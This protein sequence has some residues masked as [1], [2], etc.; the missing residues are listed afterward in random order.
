MVFPVQENAPKNKRGAIAVAHSMEHSGL[1]G[2][3]PGHLA[4]YNFTATASL[5]STVPWTYF[6]W[7]DF[8]AVRQQRLEDRRLGKQ[9][10]FPGFEHR[11]PKAVYVARHCEFARERLLTALAKRGVEIDSI[12]ACKPKGTGTPGWPQGL[13]RSDKIG[14][15]KQYR[16][17]IA[18]E[19]AEERGYVTEK[20][21][22]GYKAGSVNVYLGAPNVDDYVPDGTYLNARGAMESEAALD[23]L[24]QK[25]KK[26]L[27]EKAAW[28]SYHAPL[29][30]DMASWS[31]GRFEKTLGWSKE[32]VDAQCRLCRLA[33]GQRLGIPFNQKTQQLEH[34]PCAAKL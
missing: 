10:H 24:A 26:A 13:K 12:S 1:F 21:M 28:E 20:I 22:D 6:T 29:D 25:L 33:L 7:K 17:Y 18:F 30:A 8:Q 5:D 34:N 23:A 14:A 32:G 4:K 3:T 31:A 11:L 19:N 2:V 9:L 27:T 16:A 15:L